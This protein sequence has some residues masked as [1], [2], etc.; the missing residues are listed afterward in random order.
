M[1]F[2]PAA[3]DGL[4]LYLFLFIAGSLVAVQAARSLSASGRG[5]LLLCGA[6]LR[7]TLVWRAPDLSDDVYRYLWD[8]RVARS[9]IS[10]YRYAPDD[11]ALSAIDP[12]WR[13]RV[14]HR[15]IRTVYP[16]VAQAVFR[17]FGGGGN[18]LFLK[19]ALALA[20]LS[21]VAL[22]AAG[23]GGAFAAALYAFHPLPV[24]ETA[25]EG[26]VDSLGAALLLA[27]V[28]Y[29]SGKPSWRRRM[30][31]GL[32]FA[33]SILTKYVAAAAVLPVFRRGKLVCVASAL[34]LSSVLWFA[35]SRQAG[36]AGG[37][38]QFATRW[39]FNSILYPA[40]VR[41][42][43]ATGLPEAAKDLWIEWK[44]RWG[45]PRW[46]DRAFPYFYSAFFA[47]GLLALLLAAALIA[48]LVRVRDLEAAAFASL[49]ALLIF[50]PTLYPWYVIWILPFAARRREPAFLF[51]S[52]CIPI[53]YALAFPLPGVAPA[54]ILAV[55]YV[56]FAVLLA[57]TLRNTMRLA[58]R[59][60]MA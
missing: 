8:G 10:P 52:F 29:L 45:S 9:G 4:V 37:L 28:I 27:T 60:E 53:A 44:D 58:D 41:L 17:I 6:L 33:L 2:R 54:V 3:R 14:A 50:S 31:A 11:P 35:A 55:E 21:I 25:G 57:L 7:L 30:A 43:D 40:A 13:A 24:T 34:A 59:A 47:R 22:L 16:P 48:I 46:A 42:M 18:V 49:A 1:L 39:D 15:E 56:P 32:T 20:D 26:H 51:L 19:S 5:F 23:P 38:D 12:P 36:P